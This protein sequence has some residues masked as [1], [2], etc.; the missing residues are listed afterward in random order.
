MPPPM[1]LEIAVDARAI[2]GK[3]TSRLRRSGIVPG[4]V[5]GRG[6]ASVPVQLDAKRL[7][8]LYRRAGRTSV[9]GLTVAGAQSTSAI[10]RSVQRHPVSGQPLH[11]DFFVVDLTQEMQADIPLVVSGIAPAVEVTGGSLFLALDHIKVRALPGDLPREVT[12]DVSG[13]ADLEATIHVGDLLLDR[14]KVHVLNDPDELVAKVSPPRV[15]EE[16]EVVA[17]AEGEGEAEAVAEGEGAPAEG[18]EAG[19]ES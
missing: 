11:V 14:E 12:V 4:V 7:E 9:I 18:A 15:E 1:D 3:Q 16:P 8:T 19:S 17:E 13:L 2:T 10:I 6:L 5:F